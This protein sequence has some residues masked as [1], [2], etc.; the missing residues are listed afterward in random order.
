MTLNGAVTAGPVSGA[1][2]DVYSVDTATRGLTR[3]GVATTDSSGRFS[4]TVTANAP[5]LC[6][7]SGGS[8]QDEATGGTLSHSAA[9][10]L[11]SLDDLRPGTF[12]VFF[13]T[14]V[15]GITLA[16]SINPLTKLASLQAVTASITSAAV[17]NESGAFAIN[18]LVAREFGIGTGVTCALSRHETSQT[19]MTPLSYKP[20]PPLRKFALACSSP[21]FRRSL[22]SSL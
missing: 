4:V 13:G 8:Y 11:S 17:F 7:A 1:T 21:D 15:E 6:V 19:P 20:I 12:E 14:G 10:L 2:V 5:F 9:P 18:E 22:T 3:I 16:A